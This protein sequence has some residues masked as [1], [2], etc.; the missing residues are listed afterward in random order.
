MYPVKFYVALK[1]N[2]GTFLVCCYRTNSHMH[3]KVKKARCLGEGEV[4]A[5]CYFQRREGH[6]LR[7]Y[8]C[9]WPPILLSLPLGH[10]S[11]PRPHYVEEWP[12]DWIVAMKQTQPPM[13]HPKVFFP[14]LVVWNVAEPR[15]ETG[16][17]NQML[18]SES[19]REENLGPWVPAWRAMPRWDSVWAEISLCLVNEFRSMSLK[20]VNYYHILLI[21]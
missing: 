2:R 12:H 15:S 19:N 9:S 21:N 3:Y 18:T 11:F 4:R 6:S 16:F 5:G 14:P 1:E 17:E 10:R 20:A 7:I 8:L 13:W